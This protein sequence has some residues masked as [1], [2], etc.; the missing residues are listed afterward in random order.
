M[1]KLLLPLSVVAALAV[2]AC[3]SSSVHEKIVPDDL[4]VRFNVVCNDASGLVTCDPA[5]GQC[6]CGGALGNGIACGEGEVCTQPTGSASPTCVSSA[7]EDV[8]CDRYESCDPRDGVCKCG[9]VACAP[10]STCVD[11]TCQEDTLCKGVTCREGETCDPADGIC[12]CGDDVCSVGQSCRT[13]GGVTQCVG[14]LCVGNNC[15]EGTV[16]SPLDGL[17]H[18]GDQTGPVCSAGQAC[19]VG[20]DAGPGTCAGTDICAG[21]VCQGGTTCSPLDG[22]CRCG[23]YD[24]AA[25]VCGE[26][27]TCDQARR[28][29]LGGDLCAEVSCAPGSNTS[30]DEEQGICKC[31]GTGGVVCTD[32][33]GCVANLGAPTCVTKCNP[34]QP[35]VEKDVCGQVGNQLKGCYYSAADKIAFCADAGGSSDGQDCKT[36]TDCGSGHHCVQ[37]SDGGGTCRAYCN[38]TKATGTS[39]GCYGDNR[40]CVALAGAGEVIPNLGVCMVLSN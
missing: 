15:A 3:G 38:T 29:C 36:A 17:C 31:G 20:P 1:K 32:E 37:A 22:Q 19:E 18:C 26:G 5:D 10:G 21:V 8:T 2:S 9:G 34:I 16:C 23:G 4:C 12:K 25:P 13:E 35:G 39:G 7:C 40:V 28:Q 33:Q 11:G 27:Q 24:A 6:K 30:C 14:R